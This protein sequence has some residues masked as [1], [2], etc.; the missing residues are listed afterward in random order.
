MPIVDK[1]SRLKK[2]LAPIPPLVFE[3]LFFFAGLGAITY[4]CWLVFKALGWVVGGLIGVWLAT[5]ISA[6]RA[7]R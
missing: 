3:Q 4:G 7:G 2:A 6:E 1:Y 5:M